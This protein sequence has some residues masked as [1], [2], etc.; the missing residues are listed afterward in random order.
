MFGKGSARS[1]SLLVPAM[2]WQEDGGR[3]DG[4]EGSPSGTL[5]QGSNHPKSDEWDKEKKSGRRR[6][7]VMG[8]LEEL[9]GQEGTFINHRSSYARLM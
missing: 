1:E 5:L 4:E 6:T 9:R 7:Y 2:P 8:S 3:H